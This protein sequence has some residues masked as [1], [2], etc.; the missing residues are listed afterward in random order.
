MP[1]SGQRGGLRAS[2]GVIVL[3]LIGAA[4]AGLAFWI[5]PFRPI[6]AELRLVVQNDS[7]MATS[8]AQLPNLGTP[9]EPRFALVLGLQNGG[10]RVAR[11]ERV[12]LSVP[13]A[14]RLR[15]NRKELQRESVPG[16][17]LVR[18]E[19]PIA[20]RQVA[21]DGST[22][23][24]APGDTLWL[25]PILEDYYCTVL[26]DSVPE[27]VPAPARRPDQLANLQVFYAFRE[28]QPAGRQAGLLQLQLDPAA[29]QNTPAAM[30]PAFPVTIREPEV[31]RPE[32]GTLREGG[33]RTA[34]CGDPQQPLELYTVSWE[35]AGRGRFMVVYVNGA[36]RKQL[37]DLNR[38]SIIELE[39]W[40]ANGDG[41]FEAARPARYPIPPFL[42]PEAAA[43]AV[44][45]APSDSLMASEEWQRLF[46]DTA[47]GPFRFLPDSVPPPVLRPRV[48]QSQSDTAWLR[49][50]NNVAAGPYRFAEN[51]PARLVKPP[52]ER[53]RGP[54]GPVPLGRPV[55][56][57][58]PPGRPD[59]IPG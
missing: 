20:E 30:P 39:M 15:S 37:Y 29:L 12:A 55:P 10:G 8:A 50:F 9:Q 43:V 34:L 45:G 41:R 3:V 19:L 47:A 48:V 23:P 44:A 33:N 7:G 35:T 2:A 11:P 42:L 49:R 36:P 52:P 56:Y 1:Y 25:E 57:P 27:F 6:P 18:Y 40:D 59:T 4:L 38:D 32:L 16:N 13:A 24:L 26:A 54:R 21:P 22:Q 5:G 31:P 28:E 53:P 58:V 17:P 14:F 46:R 51:P